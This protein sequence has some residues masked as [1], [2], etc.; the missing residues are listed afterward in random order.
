LRHKTAHSYA[1]LAAKV[2]GALVYVAGAGVENDLKRTGVIP[3]LYKNYAAQV[4][5]VPNPPVDADILSDTVFPDLA[6]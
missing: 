2:T 4:T 5:P 6:A 3:Q 1:I